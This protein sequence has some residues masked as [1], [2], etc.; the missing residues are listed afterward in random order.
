ME[1]DLLAALGIAVGLGLLVGLER[2]R[3]ESEMAGIRT[4][5]LITIFGAL[6]AALG[7]VYGG[8]VPAAGLLAVAA[9]LV[10]AN[11]V[12]LEAGTRDP[13]ATTEAAALVMFGVGAALV[14]GYT[15]PAIAT[16]GGVAVLLHWKRP[17]H[18]VVRGI[19]YGELKA[20]MRLALIALVILP[21]L[22]DRAYGP[23]AVL[24]PFEIWLMVVLI[25]GISMAAYVAYQLFGAK[26]GTLAA[27]LL[28]GLISSTAATVG[29][30][31]RTR[32]S[33]DLAPA[34]AVMITIASGVVF[35]RVLLEVGVVAPGLLPVIG[36]PLAAML[37]LFAVLSTAA[38]LLARR[39]LASPSEPGPPSDLRAAIVFGLLYAA[40]LLGVAAARRYLGE[41]GLYAV[42]TLSGLTDVDAITLS[43]AQMVRAAR[44]EPD[45]GW[46]LILV[47]ALA[48]VAFKGAAVAVLGTRALFGRVAVWFGLALA[49]GLAILFLWP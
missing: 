37:G 15:T 3:A 42:A 43:T 40:V 36:P 10:M 16:G 33:P 19:D 47:G 5:P 22:P 46:R 24:N 41:T 48:N 6:S 31:R 2:E 14:A 21:V 27:G 4:F 1:L 12:K 23:L 38:Y 7:G 13:G 35:A 44:I 18:A 26:A 49:G 32:H 8:W 30:S 28:G 29:Y 25:V 45:T 17:L 39:G 11:V 9:M 34:A 20:I